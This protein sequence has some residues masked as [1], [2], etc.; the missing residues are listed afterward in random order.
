M[1][2]EKDLLK[3]VP[4]LNGRTILI[5]DGINESREIF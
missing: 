4:D 5:Y 3:K 2:E 1:T